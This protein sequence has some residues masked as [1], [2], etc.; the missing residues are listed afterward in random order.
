MHCTPTAT[1]SKGDPRSGFDDARFD[2]RDRRAALR[3]VALRLARESTDVPEDLRWSYLR[4]LRTAARLDQPLSVVVLPSSPWPADPPLDDALMD[5]MGNSGVAAYG[6]RRFALT[7]AIAGLA[8]ALLLPASLSES[9]PWTSGKDRGA[10]APVD[11][12]AGVAPRKSERSDA[13]TAA[14][15]AR[16]ERAKRSAVAGVSGGRR[17]RVGGKTVS[18]TGS[19]DFGV[20]RVDRP[21][22]LKWAAGGRPLAIRSK[23]WSLS[24]R[25]GSGTTVLT[26]GAYRRFAVRSAGSW[27][28]RLV[29][30]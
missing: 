11:P 20:L 23:D 21:V 16:A 18:G 3:D 27:T 10:P 4:A 2:P 13:V 12:H 26:P 15:S 7:G 25:G 29:A 19:R 6:L 28:V 8:A 22:L 14:R 9:L 1:D 30:P 5:S 24:A 17:L